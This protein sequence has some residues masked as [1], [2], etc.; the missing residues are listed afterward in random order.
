MSEV[1]FLDVHADDVVV[2]L[3]ILREADSLSAQALDMGAEVEVLPLD[4]PG[5]LL[6]DPVQV[7]LG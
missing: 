3:L 7:L 6:A 1:I 2:D 5:T 4:P